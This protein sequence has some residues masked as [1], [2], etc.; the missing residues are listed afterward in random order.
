MIKFL[1]DYLTFQDL[2]SFSIVNKTC[3]NIF[4]TYI[5]IR[6]HSETAFIKLFE[7]DNTLLISHIDAKRSEYYKAFKIDIPNK[8]KAIKNLTTISSLVYYSSHNCFI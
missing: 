5:H 3:N 7:K 2:N 4:K 8:E 1:L 6:I